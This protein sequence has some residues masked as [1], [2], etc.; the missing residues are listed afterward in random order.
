MIRDT[1][2]NNMV[3]YWSFD[4]RGEE[5]VG[6]DVLDSAA[7]ARHLVADGSNKAN[8]T[9]V[10]GKNGDAFLQAGS[11]VR[12]ISDG[13]SWDFVG[14]PFSVSMW[15]NFTA[16]QIQ[17]VSTC[18]TFG[19]SFS[20]YQAQLVFTTVSSGTLQFR[21]WTGS[22]ISTR[23]VA[24]M[25]G[26]LSEGWNNIVCSYRPNESVVF[27]NG[28]IISSGAITAQ[29]LGNGGSQ[30]ILS[31]ISSSYTREAVDELFVCQ[32]F[33]TQQIVD[34]LYNDGDGRFFDD[35]FNDS[36]TGSAVFGL[37][38]AARV[39]AFRTDAQWSGGLRQLLIDSTEPDSEGN[40]GLSLPQGF[41]VLLQSHAF[42]PEKWL[43]LWRPALAAEVG[44]VVFSNGDTNPD[45]LVL[46]CTSA[47]TTGSTEPAWP[48]VGATIT[49][50]SAQWEVMGQIKTLA[51][52][53]NYFV[54]PS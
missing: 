45:S 10:D 2:R 34:W 44:E 15:I 26:L 43:G 50:G 54:V 18:W 46:L 33:A 14:Q 39:Y 47:G 36:F 25:N 23:S 49:D 30:F 22:S 17:F 12:Y 21:L 5:V 7:G 32:T 24:G 53:S 4:L 48:S 51:P 29:P 28:T 13:P 42:D 27:L 41:R 35:I 6:P 19:S 1:L 9:F 52:R 16:G 20:A 38:P 11:A 37:R 31:T 8:A 40:Y 3:A